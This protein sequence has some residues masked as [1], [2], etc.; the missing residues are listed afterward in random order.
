M[1][2][3]PNLLELVKFLAA[4]YPVEWK[5]AHTGNAMT[6]DFIKI[7]AREA[8]NFDER[9]GLNGKRGVSTDISDDALNFLGEGP[10]TDPTT[11]KPCSVIDVIG[12]AGGPSPTPQWNV[13]SD[14]NNPIKSAWVN[15]L[16]QPEDPEEPPPTKPYPGDDFFRH[17]VGKVLEADYAEAGQQLNDGSSVW[18]ARTIWDYVIGDLT[19]EES[20]AKHRKEWREVLGLPPLP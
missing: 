17:S 5:N 9:F 14:P 16:T 1:S 6:E 11:G 4:K 2:N 20:V 7:L 8:H 10:D 3:V 12:G 19:I 15:P 13:V 18:F